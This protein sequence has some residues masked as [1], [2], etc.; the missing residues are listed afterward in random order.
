MTSRG[1]FRIRDWLVQPSLNRLTRGA[2]SQPLQP[3]FMDLLVFLAD[4]RGKVVSKED[5]LGAVWAKE[6]VSEGTLTHAIAVIR[7]VLGDS[8]KQP[9]Y[10]ETIPTRGYRLIA[11]VSE[12]G[13]T[14]GEAAAAVAVEPAPRARPHTLRIALIALGVVVVGAVAFKLVTASASRAAI[15][16]PKRIVVLPFKNLG[17]AGRDYLASGIT[18]D[19][20]TRLASAHRLGV[21]SRKSAEYCASAGL[22]MRQIAS[23]LGVD[24]LLEG[25]VQSDLSDERRNLVRVNA[26]LVNVR[27]D[28][29]LWAGT[30]PAALA[31]IFEVSATISSHVIDELG[32]RVGGGERSRLA[33]QPS[34]DLDAYQAY[35][36]GMRYRDLESREQLGLAV[37]M[38]ER[39]TKLDPSFAL[40]FAELSIAH[41][42]LYLLRFDPT[43]G[44]LE[45]AK[46]AVDRALALKPGLPEA[47][48]AMG[49]YSFIALR[50]YR[51][52]LEE[53]DVAAREMPNDAAL[54]GLIADVH[55][56]QG[57]WSEARAEIEHVVSLDPRNYSATLAL[58][59]TL[60]PLR[61]YEE[62]DRAFVRAVNLMP[63][64]VHPYVR[65]FWNFLL[66]DG[67]TTRAAQVLA[68]MPAPDDPD[69][70]SCRFFLDYLQRDFA[71]ALD[72]LGSAPVE[73]PAKLFWLEPK[74]LLE[75][76]CAQ[77]AG[78][79]ARATDSCGAALALLEAQV[80]QRP[81]DPRAQVGLAKAYALLGRRDDA[82]K[83]AAKA[84]S[85]C[86]VAQDAY[87]GAFYL[88][89]QAAVAARVG[90]AATALA[91][92][93][94]LL[95]MP[96]FV[97]VNWLRLDPQFDPLRRDPRFQALLAR[98]SKGGRG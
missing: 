67:T 52:A 16:T 98:W 78:D 37:A 32:V 26:Q 86:P 46:A 38:F 97:S 72:V 22:S 9:E 73:I 31:N 6:F 71:R 89:E 48:M 23:E 56:R 18:D 42:R 4:N 12:A 43:P 2:E 87:E 91:N 75:C 8:V 30:Y 82:V 81:A 64:T 51:R 57:R 36:F 65:R 3:R 69:A 59:D 14:S 13:P 88:L 45:L 96:G 79:R 5:I 61:E 15:G 55:R 40:A 53:F 41:S 19:I 90:D 62:A 94:Q 66:W 25:T 44:R 54:L 10:I 84:V 34:S 93:D 85:L 11:P 49:A 60:L 58:G 68:E 47:H 76:E 20:T 7:Q 83:A 21:I 63:D 24:Y 95:A 92:L 27:D 17:P 39:A 1:D 70:V 35:L 33:A 77:A 29:H 50:D 74:P 80:R 28:T